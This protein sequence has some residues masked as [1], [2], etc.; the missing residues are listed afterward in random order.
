[1]KQS[2]TMMN[3]LLLAGVAAAASF[4]YLTFQGSRDLA[5]QE[6]SSAEAY[7]GNVFPPVLVFTSKPAPDKGCYDLKWST[8]NST[9]CKASWNPTIVTNGSETVCRGKVD[10]NGVRQDVSPVGNITYAIT[11]TGPAGTVSKSINVK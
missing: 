10:M 3:V 11:C 2:S 5:S 8:I 9:S 4:S 7:V 1:M 6:P